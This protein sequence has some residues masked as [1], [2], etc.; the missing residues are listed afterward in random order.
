ME[1]VAEVI[2]IFFI[3]RSIRTSTKTIKSEIYCNIV[4]VRAFYYGSGRRTFNVEHF[5][6]S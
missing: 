5:Q 2:L 3:N 6:H 4:R 1:V